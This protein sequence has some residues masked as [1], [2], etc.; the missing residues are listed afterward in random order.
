MGQVERRVR[1][2]RGVAASSAA[3]LIA[4]VAHLVAG[5]S[6]AS[7]LLVVIPMVLCWL[8]GVALIGARPSLWR[9]AAVVVPA[10]AALHAVFAVSGTA[11]H[12]VLRGDTMPGMRGPAAAMT[13]VGAT[14]SPHASAAMWVG[15]AL[16]ALLTVLVWQ[17]GERAVRTVVRVSRDLLHAALPAPLH[18]LEPATATA[19]VPPSARRSP[20]RRRAAEN[21][22]PRRGPPVRTALA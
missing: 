14:S 6:I 11:P 20:L 16:A 15:H 8:P 7:P 9:Q 21:R 10:Q 1:V 13:S 18:P 2:A 3:T 22:H 19:A 5:G 4:L 17:R 12:L